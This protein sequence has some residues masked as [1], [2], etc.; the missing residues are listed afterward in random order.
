MSKVRG[1]VS[2]CPSPP[3]VPL[4]PDGFEFLEILKDVAQDNTDNPDLSILWID[5]EDFP[6]VPAHPQ[7]GNTSPRPPP[8]L[9]GGLEGG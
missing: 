9:W 8:A 6:L 3:P 5:P 7:G 1:G 4:P 2:R